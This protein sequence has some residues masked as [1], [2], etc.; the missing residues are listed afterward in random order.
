MK[1]IV[2]IGAGFAGL[3]SAVAAARRLE[4]IGQ[5]AQITLVN[6][7]PYHSIRVRN[8]EMDLS[9][10]LIELND[11]LDPIGVDLVVGRVT[12]IDTGARRLTIEQEGEA[13]HLDYDKLILASGSKLS[14]PDIPGLRDHAF[15]IDTYASAN[16]LHYHLDALPD[17]DARAGQFTALVIGSGATGVEL[18]AE[19]PARL[20]PLAA[21]RGAVA[22]V[23]LADRSGRI[24]P[25]LGGGGPVIERACNELGVEMLT[26][27]DIVKI[28][29]RGAELGDGSRID[30]STII[31]CGGMKADELTHEIS[32][33]RDRAGRL[34]VDAHMAVEGVPDI[35]AAGDAAHALIDGE[36]PSV[37]SCQHAR[38][39][40]RYAGANAV[41]A[42][43]GKPLVPLHIDWYTNIVDLG[44]WGAVYTQ[45]W[46]R[47]VVSVGASAK[48]TKTVINRVRIYPPR[49]GQRDAILAGGTIAL[50]RPP[51]LQPLAVDDIE[52]SA[53]EAVA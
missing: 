51:V 4:E 44:P 45:G 22:R 52:I 8:Y 23:I 37:M 17:L 12:A 47:D 25:G 13:V 34:Y 53:W 3:W 19:L 24:A 35:F 1:Q 49:N 11:V 39:M 40:G 5:I 21:R 7:T 26:G 42:L 32:G 41:N 50:E 31:W 29:D 15:D 27:V 36:R 28:D 46:D 14:W 6:L 38:P 10:T 43:Y 9:D 2:I 16:R 48:E 18:A 30:A 33:K 20:G